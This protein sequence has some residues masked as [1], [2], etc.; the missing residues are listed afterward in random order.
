M[1]LVGSGC[2]GIESTS[3]TVLRIDANVVGIKVLAPR[4][5]LEGF[6]LFTYFPHHGQD[7][8]WVGDPDH[9]AEDAV[10]KDITVRDMGGSGIWFNNGNLHFLQNISCL[11]NGLHGIRLESSHPSPNVNAITAHHLNLTGNLGYGLYINR[12]ESNVLQ[13]VIAQGNNEFG[14]YLNYPRNNIFCY[15]ENNVKGSIRMDVSAYD[16][17]VVGTMNEGDPLVV[18]RGNFIFAQNNSKFTLRLFGYNAMRAISSSRSVIVLPTISAWS[19][20]EKTLRGIVG[21]KPG[22]CTVTATPE[23]GDK[24]ESGRAYGQNDFVCPTTVNGFLYRCLTPGTSGV[25]E[26]VWPTNVGERITDG[27]AVW[28]CAGPQT[29]EPGLVWQVYPKDTDAVIIRVTNLTDVPIAPVMR[30][31]QIT[32]STWDD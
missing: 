30:P 3:A 21:A 12:S 13:N 6:L 8:I 22:H 17:L 1:A 11:Y 20:Y 31:W 2:T 32:V 14:I 25:K 26:P 4:C 24:W 28:T 23:S 19:S 10:L 29:I 27:T 5:R 7:G 15:T 16:C 9:D 18:N